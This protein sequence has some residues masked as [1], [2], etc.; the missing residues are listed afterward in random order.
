MKGKVGRWGFRCALL[1]A[2]AWLLAG[3]AAAPP[4]N[5]LAVWVPSPNYNA[6]QASMI[7]LHF[8]QQA[9]V[10]DALHTLRTHNPGGP[11]SAH[12]LIGKDGTIY[13][14]VSETDRAWHAGDSWWGL[15]DDV[16][17]RSIGIELDNNGNEPF[18]QPQV[19]SLLRLLTDITT[20]LHIPR[21]AIVGH[22]DIAPTRKDDPGIWFPWSE[23]AAHGFGLWYDPGPLPDPPPDFD[24]MFALRLIGY[25]ITDPTAAIVAYH[26]HY[27]SSTA[28][29]LD[30]GDLRILWNL[31]GK[32]MRMGISKPLPPAR[33]SVQPSAVRAD[34]TR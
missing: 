10:Q 2:L 24:P 3:C 22:A 5:P 15:T 33:P 27:R 11:V 6:R 19:D 18:A 7:V 31:Q 1:V 23:L 30:A 9:N 32:V 21:T 29:L 17:S 26:E 14:L 8:T 25:D 13:Q 28:P 4:R 20:R 34:S 16:N 12:Y